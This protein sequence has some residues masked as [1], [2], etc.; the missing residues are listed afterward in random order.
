MKLNVSPVFW[1][2]YS[3]LYANFDLI[4]VLVWLNTKHHILLFKKF[5]SR[6]KFVHIFEREGY[7][8]MFVTIKEG[9]GKT[10]QNSLMILKLI[11]TS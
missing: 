11:S 7:W 2:S 10:C 3:W 1:N 5:V 6:A 9:L 8:Y 4:E